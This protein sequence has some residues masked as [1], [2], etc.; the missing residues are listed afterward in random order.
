MGSGD[1]EVE[2]GPGAIAKLCVVMDLDPGWM[3]PLEFSLLWG[4]QGLELNMAA[5]HASQSQAR[6]EA[7][8]RRGSW[9]KRLQ[10]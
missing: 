6:K 10:S 7:A 3:G 5:S 8:P 1:G 9:A 2:R 4:P